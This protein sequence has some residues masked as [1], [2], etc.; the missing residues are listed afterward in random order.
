MSS[1]KIFI[2]ELL[3]PADEQLA[4]L[5]PAAV[6]AEG[7]NNSETEEKLTFPLGHLMVRPLMETL[8][9]GD[10]KC[11]PGGPPAN[12]TALGMETREL[13][14]KKGWQEM[15]FIQTDPLTKAESSHHLLVRMLGD[16]SL[17]AACM[18]I[19]KHRVYNNLQAQRRGLLGKTQELTGVP[20]VVMIA[21]A[22]RSMSRLDQAG[23]DPRKRCSALGIAMFDRVGRRGGARTL[24]QALDEYRAVDGGTSEARR[25]EGEGWKAAW[26][27]ALEI[28]VAFLHREGMAWADVSSDN[29]M[30]QGDELWIYH[31][32][33]RVAFSGSQDTGMKGDDPE[34]LDDLLCTELR[35]SEGR[36]SPGLEGASG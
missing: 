10:L 3:N 5:T 6:E 1:A 13:L 31:F 33:T 26:G 12:E 34:H 32:G 18:L 11:N 19:D 28:E 2:H 8:W 23:M 30:V 7:R 24:R 22:D 27:E 20:G 21:S 9:T 4:E 15:E 29:V 35:S 36:P 17:V 16:L 25:K 14:R